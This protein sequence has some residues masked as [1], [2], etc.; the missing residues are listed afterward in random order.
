MVIKYI[1]QRTL[2]WQ[3]K[4]CVSHGK[5]PKVEKIKT[6]KFY[7]KCVIC[8]ASEIEQTANFV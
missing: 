6:Q 3:R 1:E 8:M 5:H 2:E 4:Y 7:E